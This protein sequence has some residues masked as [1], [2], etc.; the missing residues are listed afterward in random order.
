LE[1]REDLFIN[2]TTTTRAKDFV[3][4]KKKSPNRS[5]KKLIFLEI[6]IKKSFISVKITKK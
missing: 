2:K 3:F 1:K 4:T 6:L 5:I